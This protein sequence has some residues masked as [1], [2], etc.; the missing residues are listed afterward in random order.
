MDIN[1][2]CNITLIHDFISVDN[3]NDI[4]GSLTSRGVDVILDAIDGQHEKS[5]LIAASCLHG[6]PIVTCGG[7]AGRIDPTQIVC[8]DLTKSTDCRLLF[9]CKKILRDKYKLFSKGQGSK[10]YRA[11][12][13][14]IWS[15]FSTELQKKVAEGDDGGDGRGRGSLRRCDGA[16]GT[17]CFVTGTYGFVAASKIVSMIANDELVKPKILNSARMAFL[18]TTNDDRQG[19]KRNEIL[20]EASL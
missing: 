2:N 9:W 5:A 16:L 13:W 20:E 11:R 1:P 17:S 7:A 4:V 18:E 14:R 6:M 19:K 12:K 10:K 3:A 15:V 8:D